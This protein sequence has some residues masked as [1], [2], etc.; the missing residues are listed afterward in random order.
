MQNLKKIELMS[1][2]QCIKNLQWRCVSIVIAAALM[3][4]TGYAQELT[5]FE[6]FAQESPGNTAAAEEIRVMPGNSTPSGQPD[7][8]LVGTSNIGSSRSALLA[9]RDGSVIRVPLAENGNSPIPDYPGYELRDLQAGK[10]TLMLTG[11]QQCVSFPEKGVECDPRN[12]TV[13]LTLE[14]RSAQVRSGDEGETANESGSDEATPDNPFARIR[15]AN[16]NVTNQTD[17]NSQRFRPRRIPPEDV[18]PGMRVI[19]TPFGDRLVQE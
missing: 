19:S 13:D 4:V 15:E 10:V 2:A 1:L 7:F 5:L 14:L 17:P 9:N 16:A 8:T 3:P 18:P 6:P 11:G 12:N